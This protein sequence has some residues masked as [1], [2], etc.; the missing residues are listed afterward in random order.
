[1][2]NYYFSYGSG[3]HDTRGRKLDGYYVTIEAD[4]QDDAREKYIALF[5]DKWS[6]TYN[7]LSVPERWGWTELTFPYDIDDLCSQI[8][9]KDAIKMPRYPRNEAEARRL[10]Q[11]LQE[12]FGI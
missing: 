11:R 9:Q 7:D 12:D 2:P 1:M 8:P 6:G 10:Q 5:G 3:H 4:T